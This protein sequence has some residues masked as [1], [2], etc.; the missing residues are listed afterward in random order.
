MAELP[1][2]L[3]ARKCGLDVARGA[4]ARAATVLAAGTPGD[5]AYNRAI[6]DFDFWLR[7]DRNRRN[8]GTT[9][10][11]LAAALFVALR[12]GRIEWPLRYYAP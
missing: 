11:L 7:A 9:A 5:T 3:I 1:D 10:D 2:S 6:A 12:D 4:S 8:P